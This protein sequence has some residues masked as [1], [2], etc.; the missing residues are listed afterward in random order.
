MNGSLT[1]AGLAALLSQGW[2][3]SAKGNPTRMVG[4]FRLTVFQLRKGCYRFAV[5]DGVDVAYCAESYATEA[6]AADAAMRSV[7]EED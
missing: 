1:E 7:E 5:S 6:Q 4:R 3:R 2:K